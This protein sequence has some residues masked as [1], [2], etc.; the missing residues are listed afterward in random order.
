MDH[1]PG[2]GEVDL[3]GLLFLPSF[4]SFGLHLALPSCDRDEVREVATRLPLELVG[5]QGGPGR[6]GL[7]CS[8]TTMPDL[9]SWV[10]EL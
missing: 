10:S 9:G 7:S 5:T 2:G 1:S 6:R 4:S 3:A 8:S